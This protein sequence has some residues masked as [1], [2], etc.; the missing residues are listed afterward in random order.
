MCKGD[1]VDDICVAVIVSIGRGSPWKEEIGGLSCALDGS[2]APCWRRSELRDA[3]SL[4][5][6]SANFDCV[7]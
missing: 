6:H 3:R 1:R 4:S 7:G 5:S 2:G